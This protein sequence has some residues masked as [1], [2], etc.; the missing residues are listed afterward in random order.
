MTQQPTITELAKQIGVS[1]RTLHRYLAKP[2]RPNSFDVDEWKAFVDATKVNVP[3]E[4]SGASETDSGAAV[5]SY[6]DAR[7]RK[8]VA[9]ANMAE[10]QEAVIKRNVFEK[11]EVYETLYEIA[12]TVKRKVQRLY[13][14]ELPQ[15]LAGLGPVEVS[16]ILRDEFDAMLGDI[17]KTL[18]SLFEREPAV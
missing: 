14:S 4:T 12:G 2:N 5:E 9:A 16:E 8:M 6:I 15:R 7:A 11:A 10:I 17:S 18:Q 13:S 1:R 3:E